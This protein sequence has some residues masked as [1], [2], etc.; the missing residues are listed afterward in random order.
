MQIDSPPLGSRVRPNRPRR[1]SSLPQSCL[2]SITELPELVSQQ[3]EADEWIDS[4]TSSS[5]TSDSSSDN[6]E[7]ESG[8]WSRSV[9]DKTYGRRRP[10]Q[11]SSFQRKKNPSKGPVLKKESVDRECGIW[12][13]SL[14]S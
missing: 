4:S 11:A 10:P 8:R 6:L 7:G 14:V 2:C 5:L 9:N 12:Y 13:V 3:S 1:T